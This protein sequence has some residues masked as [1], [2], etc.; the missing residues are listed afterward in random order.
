MSSRVFDNSE[1]KNSLKPF[2]KESQNENAAISNK[3]GNFRQTLR[4]KRVPLGGKNQNTNTFELNRSKSTINPNLSSFKYTK[5]P[6]LIK[7]NSSLGFQSVPVYQEHRQERKTVQIAAPAPRIG[8]TTER[9]PQKDSVRST[10]PRSTKNVRK[11]LSLDEL[12]RPTLLSPKKQKLFQT[13]SLVKSEH[14]KHAPISNI[15]STLSER[16]EAINARHIVNNDITR[17]NM[18]PIKRSIRRHSI[19]TMVAQHWKDEI[20]FVPQDYNKKDGDSIVSFND[21]ELQYF[22][23]PNISHEHK[24]TPPN[25]D[26]DLD[27]DLDLDFENDA[28]DE[29]L[30]AEMTIDGIENEEFGLNDE[31]LRN[32]LD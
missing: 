30:G 15:Q 17:N 24:L 7:S 20:E 28:G 11:R 29:E 1:N 3:G 16:T 22:S 4:F 5:P 31:D 10:G 12:S 32:L 2:N 19:D 27:L 13:D 25:E 8:E 23:T 18:D 6:S 21:D 14:M 9:K 26:L